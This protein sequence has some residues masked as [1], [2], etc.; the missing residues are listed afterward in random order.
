LREGTRSELLGTLA[1][2]AVAGMIT[3]RWLRAGSLKK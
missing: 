2:I 1:L 3:G